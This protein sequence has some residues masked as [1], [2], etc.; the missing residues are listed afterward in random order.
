MSPFLK[1][2]GKLQ[3]IPAAAMAALI[4]FAGSCLPAWASSPVLNVVVP[5]ESAV[6]RPFLVYVSS[7]SVISGLEASWDGKTVPMDITRTGEVS[8]A[9]VLLGTDVADDVPGIKKIKIQAVIDGSAVVV[10]REIKVAAVEF[11]V[12]RLTLPEAM[13]TPPKELLD[14]IADERVET[15]RALATVSQAR[16]WNLPMVRPVPGTITSPYGL[17]RILNGEPR[18]PHRGVDYR[19]KDGDPVRSAADGTVIL[20]ADHY[21]PGAC[22]YVDHGSGV[23]SVYMHLSRRL[24]DAGDTVSAGEVIGLA[25][26][27]GRVTGPHL[28]FGL[29]LQGSM[30][31]P[32][33]LLER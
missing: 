8:E 2:S 30:V 5:R 24:V 21:Y 11:P 27:T 10:A 14:R 1:I 31:D 28:H 32:E 19:A 23:I 6:G 13:V 7:L 26:R 20:S 18:S 25:G 12:Q 22:I 9:M 15:A 33:P 4:L 29:S 3:G 16:K 17:R